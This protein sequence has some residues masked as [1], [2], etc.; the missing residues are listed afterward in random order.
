MNAFITATGSYLPDAVVTNEQLAE[1]LGLTPEQI[2]RSC[3]IRE[4]RWAAPGDI[5]SAFAVNALTSTG[6]A[7]DQIDY[8]IFGTMTSDRYDGAGWAPPSAA[9]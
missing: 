8:L 7:A 3:G 4:R 9:G 5:T 2:F 1:R 6:V